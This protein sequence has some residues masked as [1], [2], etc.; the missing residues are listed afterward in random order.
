MEGN[1]FKNEN[2][3]TKSTIIDNSSIEQERLR[4]LCFNTN[5]SF[6]IPLNYSVN[7]LRHQILIYL[8][9]KDLSAY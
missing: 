9:N 7:E 8:Q 3:T 5:T 6:T 1:S 4:Y 2:K